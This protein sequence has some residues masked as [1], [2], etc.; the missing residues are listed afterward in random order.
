MKLQKFTIFFLLLFSLLVINNSI[1]Q[2]KTT[3][4]S[5][6]A[7]TFSVDIA[8]SFNLPIQDSRGNIGDF[9]TFQNYGTKTGWGAQFNMKFGLGPYGQYRPYITLGYSQLQNSDNTTAYID[10]NDIKYGYPL[11]GNS[12]YSS[13]PGTSTMIIRNPFIGAGFE[14]AWTNADRQKRRFIPFVGV[15]FLVNVITGIYRQTPTVAANPSF[16]QLEVPFTIKSDVRMGLGASLGANYR[17]NKAIGI[18]FGA[19]YK[20][21]NLIGKKS[22]FLLEENKM[23]LLDKAATDLN[24]NLSKSRNMGVIE[25]YLGA[26]I[27]VGKSKK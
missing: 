12:V 22:E 14:M 25:F 19:K 6:K 26:T 17:F 18:V 16:S 23:N 21:A 24:S 7:P 10:T 15:E 5:W 20:L 9:F 13:T 3:S 2:V 27:F 11:K 8:G 1:A 4:S